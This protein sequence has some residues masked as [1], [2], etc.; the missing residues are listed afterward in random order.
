MR[1]A[2]YNMILD[3]DNDVLVKDELLT[4]KELENFRKC[5]SKRNWPMQ[6]RRVR[7]N[8]ESVYFFFG[9][10]FCGGIIEKLPFN[11]RL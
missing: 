2:I 3:E 1:T 4:D 9:A 7:V 5:N 8:S 10:R 6:I 11:V